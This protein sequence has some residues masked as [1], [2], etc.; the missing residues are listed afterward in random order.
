[1]LSRLAQ[2]KCLPGGIALGGDALLVHVPY[3]AKTKRRVFTSFCI[4]MAPA[5]AAKLTQQTLTDRLKALL[6]GQHTRFTFWE[7]NEVNGTPW[8]LPVW[9]FVTRNDAQKSH[10]DGHCWEAIA[11]PQC[12]TSGTCTWA[13]QL[14]WERPDLCLCSMR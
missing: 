9:P 2:A 12:C 10:D 8:V 1:M 7:F 14:G 13:S 5:V 6:P 11:L 4:S 3:C